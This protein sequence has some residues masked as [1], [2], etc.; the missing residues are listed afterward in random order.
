MDIGG[1]YNN[2]PAKNILMEFYMQSVNVM[3]F[4]PFTA[5]FLAML[6][7]SFP[8]I[9]RTINGIPAFKNDE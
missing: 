2:V 6:T 1:H 3:Y 4:D 7:T 8:Y 5:M 9:W